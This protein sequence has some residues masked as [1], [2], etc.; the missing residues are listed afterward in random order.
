MYASVHLHTYTHLCPTRHSDLPIH[1][2]Y[3][4]IYMYASVYIHMY[5]HL[6]PTRHSDPHPTSIVSFHPIYVYI[7]IYIYYIGIYILYIHIM[8]CMCM[9]VYMHACI[10]IHM[11][12]QRSKS[13]SILLSRENHSHIK[14]VLLYI[15][16]CIVIYL[17]YDQ[18]KITHT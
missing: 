9:Y 16:E 7:Y 5:T 2:I 17:S 6:C 13:F 8:M 14:N 18:E 4:Y 11:Y 12:I 1:T 10:F 15:N 3:I